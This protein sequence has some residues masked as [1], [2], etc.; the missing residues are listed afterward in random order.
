V[1]Y[2]SNGLADSGVEMTLTGTNYYTGKTETY[3]AETG[4]D[5]TYLFPDAVRGEYTLAPSKPEAPVPANLTAADGSEIADAALGLKVLTPIQFKAADVTG[6]GRISG[7]DASRVT[8]FATGLLDEMSNTGTPAPAWQF[9]PASV[10][11]SLNA[12]T[13]DLNFAAA[14]TGDVSGNYRPGTSVKTAR[15]ATDT[16]LLK[17]RQGEMLSVPLVLTQETFIRG[18]DVRI[19]YDADM[20]TLSDL[21]LSGGILENENYEFVSNPNEPGVIRIAIFS[22]SSLTAVTGSGTVMTADFTVTGPKEFS[23]LRLERFD[24]NEIPVSASVPRSSSEPEEIITGGF[25]FDGSVFGG[26]AIRTEIDYDVNLYDL[27][28]DGRIGLEDAVQ[29]LLEGDLKTAIRALQCVTG[30]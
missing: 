20:L 9:E 21:S 3:T 2:F 24:C 17:V 19:E 18:I 15:D 14:L 6:N 1:S 28:G 27:T 10:T 4:A 26:A 22:L 16:A 7:L 29:A 23:V 11:V 25:E 8:R 5:G 12:D 30:M 13:A